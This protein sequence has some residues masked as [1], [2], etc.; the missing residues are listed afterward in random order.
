MVDIAWIFFR[1]DSLETAV[2]F[3]HNILFRFEPWVLFDRSIYM[4]GL[5]QPEFT[6]MMIAIGI[7]IF[8]DIMAYRGCQISTL[9]DQQPLIFRWFVSIAAILSIVVYGVWGTNYDASNFIYFQF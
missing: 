8:A 1:A 9:I 4:F 5:A 6:V 7:L 2:R 3:L